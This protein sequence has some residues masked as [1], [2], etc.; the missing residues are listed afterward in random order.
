MKI[1][2]SDYDG[3]LNHNGIDDKKRQALQRWHDAGN[4]FALVSGRGLKDML[5]IY[6]EQQFLCDYFIAESGALIMK[7]DGTII[8]DVRCGGDV[9]VPLLT[10]LFEKGC[11]F[12]SVQTTHTRRVFAEPEGC[13]E[14]SDC[15]LENL[16][17]MPYFNQISTILPDSQ[18]AAE[19]VACIRAQ[20][21][22]K[23][24]PLQNGRCID[25]VRADMNKARGL[26]ILMEHLGAEYDDVIAVG[27]HINDS[28][29]IREF[30]SY[31]MASGLDSIKKLA[32]DVTPGVAEM[33]EKELKG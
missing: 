1:I 11:P 28:D 27:D 2:G 7:N 22:D 5:K 25:I 19:V 30:R 31:A 20:F 32:D 6:E 15:T 33:I 18:T 26:Y 17:E 23:L 9:I 16:P 8:W 21:G 29:M 3:T 4:I 13:T 12:G 24:N 10:L 14:E